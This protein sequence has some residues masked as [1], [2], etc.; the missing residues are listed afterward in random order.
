V[1]L[2]G[3]YLPIDWKVDAMAGVTAPMPGHKAPLGMERP[4]ASRASM[5]TLGP[6]PWGGHSRLPWA[7]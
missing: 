4:H 6:G 1:P 7:P 3:E 2:K 5:R